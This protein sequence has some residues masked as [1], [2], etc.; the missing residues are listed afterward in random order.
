MPGGHRPALGL[1]CRVGRCWTSATGRQHPRRQPRRGAA[2]PRSYSVSKRRK[3]EK[4]SG[5]RLFA[6]NPHRGFPDW[7]VR[8]SVVTAVFPCHPAPSVCRPLFSPAGSVSAGRSPLG[9]C[10]ISD[11]GG[12]RMGE[13][14]GTFSGRAAPTKRLREFAGKTVP[15][16]RKKP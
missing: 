1:R 11:G 12:T 14:V 3:V 9:S 2:P 16:P 7:A 4:A 15:P 5:G 13:S 8:S 10:A 6:G